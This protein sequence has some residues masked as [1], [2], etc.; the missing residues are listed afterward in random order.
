M[1]LHPRHRKLYQTHLQ[2]ERQKVLKLID[3]MD[4]NRFT[5][6]SSL[7]R[8]RRLSLHAGLAD[9]AHAGLASAKID[10]PPAS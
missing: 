3:D 2:R 1:D 9:E 8:L 5:I 7:T 4:A 6:L 10:A